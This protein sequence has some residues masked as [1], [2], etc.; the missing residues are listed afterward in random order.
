MRTLKEIIDPDRSTFRG[1]FYDLV[2]QLLEYDPIYR[3]T[4][5]D[6]LRHPIFYYTF[7]EDGRK[8]W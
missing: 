8:L 1:L 5:R 2:K 6:A 3:I 7:D 4:A